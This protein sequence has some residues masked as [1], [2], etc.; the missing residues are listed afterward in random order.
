MEEDKRGKKLVGEGIEGGRGYKGGLEDRV[1]QV[2][3]GVRGG[4]GYSG[5]ENVEKLGEE[6]ELRGMGGG[7]LGERQGDNVE[8]SKE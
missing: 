3:G 5:C 2:M 4:M 8:M 1:Y 7:G 6:G